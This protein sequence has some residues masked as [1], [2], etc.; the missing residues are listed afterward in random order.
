M[1]QSALEKEQPYTILYLPRQK[2]QNVDFLHS[3]E[4]VEASAETTESLKNRIDPLKPY[5]R[6][7]RVGVRQSLKI[8]IPGQ[9]SMSSLCRPLS[10]L[11]D[12]CLRDSSQMITR[13]STGK[14]AS[15]SQAI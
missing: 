6:L 3:R 12:C 13:R 2:E 10:R 11:I 7:V 1:N 8:F 14:T 5:S 15:L 4:N 9:Y